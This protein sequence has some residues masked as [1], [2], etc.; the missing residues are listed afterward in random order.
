MSQDQGQPC[1]L[2]PCYLLFYNDFNC[3][4]ILSHFIIFYLTEDSYLGSHTRTYE[5]VSTAWKTTTSQLTLG[6]RSHT[7][8]VNC[9]NYW[10]SWS[11]HT[12]NESIFNIPSKVTNSH[13]IRLYSKNHCPKMISKSPSTVDWKTT[14][15]GQS[16][17]DVT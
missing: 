17:T 10:P 15:L 6:K 7:D 12:W 1:V 14:F 8:K 4:D 3:L 16:G 2:N 13:S 11:P 9:G 5:A